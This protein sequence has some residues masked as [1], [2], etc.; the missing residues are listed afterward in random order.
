MPFAGPRLHLPGDLLA[1]LQL[2][3]PP[4]GGGGL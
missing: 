3:L 2:C 1:L 4:V